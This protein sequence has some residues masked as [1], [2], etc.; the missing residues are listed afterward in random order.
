MLKKWL[1]IEGVIERR[2]IEEKERELAVRN[3]ASNAKCF[4]HLE[5]DSKLQGEKH[6]AA[7]VEARAGLLRWP[8]VYIPW[9]IRIRSLLPALLITEQQAINSM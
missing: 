2:L 8:R 6:E 9:G 7:V 1:N 4:G 3:N 5:L